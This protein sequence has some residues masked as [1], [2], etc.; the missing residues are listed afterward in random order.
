MY[1]GYARCSTNE[2]RQ[3]ISRQVRELKLLGV[4]EAE[5]YREYESAGKKYRTELA[6]LLQAVS[7][8]D[9]IYA[10][11]VSRITRSTKQLCEFVEFAKEKKIRLVFGSFVVDCTGSTLDPFVEA[12]LKIIGVFAEIERNIIAERVKSG[13]R[14]AKA[15]GKRIGRPKTTRDNLPNSF[16][17][18][19]P[20]Y[21]A[22]Q[23][24]KREY[25]SICG[26]SYPS[27]FKYLKIMDESDKGN[28]RKDKIA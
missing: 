11:E 2:D 21:R 10:T 14:N 8:G 7:Q 5:I 15:K 4:K 27:I 12:T 9:S 25:T 16:I 1:Y 18:H 19:Y 28:S 23:I 20:L 3:D 13:M 22:G 26:I 24:N 6:R 17:K